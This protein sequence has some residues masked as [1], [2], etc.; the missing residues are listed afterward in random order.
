MYDKEIYKKARN[1]GFKLNGDDIAIIT[2]MLLECIQEDLIAGN[3]VHLPKIGNLDVIVKKAARKRLVES[4]NEGEEGK[5][6]QLYSRPCYK[7]KFT[8]T[9]AI[10][11]TLKKKYYETHDVSYE[12]VMK[13]IE[14]QEA[15]KERIKTE[16]QNKRPVK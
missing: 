10:K 4:W 6:I 2:K 11:N 13:L 15:E 3:S 5:M 14:E 8:P 7:I 9:S 12:A 16:K 1:A